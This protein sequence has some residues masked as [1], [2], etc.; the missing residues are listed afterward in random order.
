MKRNYE[1]LFNE[2]MKKCETMPH[3]AKFGPEDINA[4]VRIGTDE[5]GDFSRYSAITYALLCGYMVGYKAAKREME[6]ETVTD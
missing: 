1:K 3:Q 4:F 6:K 5:N 2:Y